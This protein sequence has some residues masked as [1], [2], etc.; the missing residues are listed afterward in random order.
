MRNL[1]LLVFLVLPAGATDLIFIKTTKDDLII[2]FIKDFIKD[3]DLEKKQLVLNWF[4][5]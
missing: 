5:E 4:E 3:V 1:L 2:P